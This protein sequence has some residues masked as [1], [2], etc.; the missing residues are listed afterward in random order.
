MYPY[1]ILPGFDFYA[2]FYMLALI[3]ALLWLRV[4]S[5][6][7]GM[8]ARVYNLSLL[9]AVAAIAGGYLASILTQSVYDW[10]KTG[11]F[12][13]GTGM[14]FYGGLL[15]G[16]LIFVA[17]YFTVGRRMF[18]RGG[19]HVKG[20]PLL[21]DIAAACVCFAHATGRIGCLFAGCCHGAETDA[22]YGI[23]HV[24]LG[25]RATPTQLFESVFLYLL[26]S[27]MLALLLHGKRGICALYLFAYGVWRF[28]IEYLRTDDRGAS[29]IPGLTPSQVSA[30][31]FAAAGIAIFA[32]RAA[33]RKK[34][35]D[36]GSAGDAGGAESGEM[37]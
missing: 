28:A 22:W 29:F 7:L 14:T 2:L 27:V 8:S 26:F 31:F 3:S 1:D 11:T 32:Y 19:D 33:S 9:S 12:R 20:A 17:V 25:Y 15:G 4:L 37:K 30:V 35:E 18:G 13:F 16:I 6:R 10:I 34:A 24:N 5:D 21:A 23:Y 36:A